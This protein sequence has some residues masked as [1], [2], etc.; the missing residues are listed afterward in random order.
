MSS[1]IFTNR[2]ILVR[3]IVDM[4]PMP[5]T[6]GPCQKYPLGGAVV[7]QMAPCI[8]TLTTR[9]NLNHP[10]HIFY[11]GK[12]NQGIQRKPMQRTGEGT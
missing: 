7:H 3:V 9:G 6:V 2:F 8:N 1:V 10:I 4:E 12:R 5:G 11:D